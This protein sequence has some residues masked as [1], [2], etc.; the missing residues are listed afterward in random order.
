M[1]PSRASER[2][3]VVRFVTARTELGPRYERACG[4][5]ALLPPRTPVTAAPGDLDCDVVIVGA[6]YTGLAAARRWAA[7]SPESDIVLLDADTVG[8]GNPGR[9]SGFLLE[10]ALAHDV[11]ASNLRRMRECNRLLAATMQAIATDVAATGRECGLE[12]T[13]TY[14]AAAGDEGRAALARYEAFLQNAG[15]DHERLDREALRARI[16]TTFYRAGLYSPHC[17]LVQPAAL[18]RALAGLLPGN[19]RLRELEPA[20][21]VKRRGDRW[22]VTTTRARIS[23]RQVVLANNAFCKDLGVGRS[24]ITAMYTYAALTEPLQDDELAECGAGRQWGLL[25][26]HRLGST[27]RRTG[28]GR[29]LIRSLYGYEREANNAL[30]EERLRAAL[31]RRFPR[32]ASTRFAATWSG[33]TGFTYN[34]APLWGEPQPGLHV[35]AGCNGGGVVKGTL[36][37]RLLAERAHGLSTPDVAALFGRASWMPPEPLRRIGFHI[38]AARERQRA[39]AEV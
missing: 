12:R 38:V 34:A 33:A 16:G 24:R 21:G 20:L 9:N 2:K 13:G 6:G 27:L 22:H 4:W 23:A 8:E 36:L 35:S 15:L 17:W 10:I 39:R 26:A 37:G 19:V 28:D 5:N 14:R 18:I 32:L 25:P 7:L 30:V 1:P 11:D 31:L 3:P 29:L